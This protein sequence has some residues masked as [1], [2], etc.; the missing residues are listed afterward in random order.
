MWHQWVWKDTLVGISGEC[1]KKHFTTLR[2]HLKCRFYTKITS[3]YFAYLC[4]QQH[5]ITYYVI[6]CLCLCLVGNSSCQGLCQN[7]GRC[8]VRV[9]V[10]PPFSPCML[11]LSSLSLMLPISAISLS[12]ALFFIINCS[13][14]C[15][16]LLITHIKCYAMQ[17]LLSESRCVCPPGFSGKYCQNGPSPCDSAP[18]LHGGQCVEKDGRTITCDCPMGYSGV[19]CEVGELS[20]W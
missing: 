10:M 16:F 20:R 9:L 17:D 8:E 12:P 19:F 5:I 11:L 3:F 15:A 2:E 4:L 18:C 14:H 13:L 6:Q 7:A 1:S